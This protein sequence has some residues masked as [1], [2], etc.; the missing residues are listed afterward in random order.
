MILSKKLYLKRGS[1]ISAWL[2]VTHVFSALWNMASRRSAIPNQS[3]RNLGL[4]ILT[5]KQNSELQ[6]NACGLCIGHCPTNALDL[7]VTSTGVVE[8][9]K[10]DILKC[11][12]CSLCQ[13]VCPIDA[14]RMGKELA[15]PNHAEGKWVMDAK[16]LSKSGIVSRLA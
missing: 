10:L 5:L 1:I 8:D 2:W 14:I 7:S 4:P 3:S 6:C 9:F 13:D 16:E 15:R 12:T 11:I